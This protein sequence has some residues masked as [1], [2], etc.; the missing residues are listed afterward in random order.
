MDYST[1][2]QNVKA[3]PSAQHVKTSKYLLYVNSVLSGTY[4]LLT[5]LISDIQAVS[6]R[7]EIQK[8]NTLTNEATL[9]TLKNRGFNCV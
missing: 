7:I 5:D 8:I 1:Q 3:S 2:S 6:G 4:L 9:F